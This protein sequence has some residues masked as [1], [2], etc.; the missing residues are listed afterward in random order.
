V[1]ATRSEA[2]SRSRSHRIDHSCGP[3][4]FSADSVPQS[5]DST[6]GIRMIFDLHMRKRAKESRKEIEKLMTDLFFRAGKRKRMKENEI[7]LP[8]RAVWSLISELMNEL[9]AKQFQLV[10]LAAD[11]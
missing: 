9:L 10:P 8:S 2:F 4:E 7:S 5:F 11:F 1:T 6:G 3:N